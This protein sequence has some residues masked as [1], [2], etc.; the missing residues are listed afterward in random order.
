MDFAIDSETRMLIDTVGRFVREKIEPLE[1]RLDCDE[2]Y[3]LAEVKKL[4]QEAIE[5]GLFGLCMP[6]EVGGGG[7]NAV[8]YCLAEEQI[9]RAPNALTSNIL[10]IHYPMLMHC[11]P[12]QR[13]LYLDPV[14]R[15]EKV[16]AIGITEP[17]A[18]S[19]ASSMRTRAIKDGDSWI[20]NGSKHFISDGDICDFVILMATTDPA[21]KARGGITAF[22]LDKGTPGFRVGRKQR[23]MGSQGHGSQTEL[24]FEDCRVGDDKVLGEVGQ[25][26]RLG[27][28]DI[29]MIRL[30]Q[31]GGRAVGM[32]NRV[33]ELCVAHANSRVQFGHKIGEFQMIQKMLA[34]MA[35]RIFAARSMMLATAWE[36]DQGLDPR[37]KV[38]MV[39]L[40]SSEMIGFVADAGIQIFGG[41]GYTTDLP[42]ERIY[43][44]CRVLR[45]YDGTSEIHRGQIAR[46]MLKNG[47]AS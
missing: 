44:D 40:Y 47:Y 27:M 37:E 4:R 1:K 9:G 7:L 16:C 36:V 42:L 20:I 23:M 5:L 45:I 12:E 25:G 31:I 2:G 29:S 28:K 14:M 34:D 33:M 11:T 39:K 24:F 17:E 46:H 8:Q 35:T 10:G 38:S 6:A 13:A 3:P 22:L 43:R 30:A 21:K 18:G 26:F 19:D 41:M 32:A 15:G